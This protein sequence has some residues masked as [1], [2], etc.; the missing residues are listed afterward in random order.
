MNCIEAVEPTQ[1]SCQEECVV[2]MP[3][4]LLGFE[5]F[6]RYA[7]FSRPTQEPFLWLKAIDDPK[8][9]FLVMSPFL[10][11]P[12]YSPDIGDEDVKFLGLNGRED[13]LMFNIVTIRGPHN[14]SVNLKGPIVLNR[15]TLQAKQIIPV[16]ASTFS[17]AHP[18]PLQ[19][20]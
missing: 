19:S 7:L 18:L 5:R 2:Q 6:K 10:A 4:G 12:S 14:A 17:V 9:A 13:S 11:L 3:L 16:N 15:N 8:L 20:S 1:S